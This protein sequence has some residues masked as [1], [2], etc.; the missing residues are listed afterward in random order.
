M[1]KVYTVRR[2]GVDEGIEQ[3]N[4]KPT[5]GE[6]VPAQLLQCLVVQCSGRTGDAVEFNLKERP[7][8]RRVESQQERIHHRLVGESAANS[9]QRRTDMPDGK[10]ADQR[11]TDGSWLPANTMPGL[12]RGTGRRGAMYQEQKRTSSEWRAVPLQEDQQSTDGEQHRRVGENA[13]LRV[14]GRLT[15]NSDE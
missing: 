6:M 5:G 9:N 14:S 2:S 11:D 3:N 12:G 8:L 15:E 4:S 7:L 1:E 13:H 10:A